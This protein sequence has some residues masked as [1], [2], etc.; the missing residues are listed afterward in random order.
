[1]LVLSLNQNPGD[2][3]LVRY[4]NQDCMMYICGCVEPYVWPVCG[5]T[6][7]TEPPKDEKLITAWE[8]SKPQQHRPVLQMTALVP[9]EKHSMGSVLFM[10]C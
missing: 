3:N 5:L 10:F 9:L 1:M 6:S 4:D 7:R 2:A 8:D